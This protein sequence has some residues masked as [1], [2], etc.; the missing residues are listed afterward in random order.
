MLAWD[1]RLQKINRISKLWRHYVGK[2]KKKND[3]KMFENGFTLFQNSKI[4]K[5]S[6][7]TT[8]S[9]PNNVI[10]IFTIERNLQPKL[11]SFEMFASI[12]WN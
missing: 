2:K 1:I 11:F 8:I 3:G 9:W 7:S 5:M 12:E 10:H 6:K 4:K